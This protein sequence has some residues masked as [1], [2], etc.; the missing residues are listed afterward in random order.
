MCPQAPRRRADDS[1]SARI[2]TRRTNAVSAEMEAVELMARGGGG[3]P[4]SAAAHAPPLRKSGDRGGRAPKHQMTQKQ[5]SFLQGKHQQRV[6][7]VVSRLGPAAGRHLEG[8]ATE[9]MATRQHCCSRASS[10]AGDTLFRCRPGWYSCVVV[11]TNGVSG[12]TGTRVHVLVRPLA[13]LQ[14]ARSTR[15]FWGCLAVLPQ[16]RALVWSV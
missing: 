10:L 7:N 16:Q 11:D 14:K 2:G 4:Q 9:E 3:I 5:M 6:G 1:G 12:C 15:F 13:Q 8:G